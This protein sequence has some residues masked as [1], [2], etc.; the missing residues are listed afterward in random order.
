MS[1][2]INC[3]DCGETLGYGSSNDN[4]NGWTRGFKW[5][6]SNCGNNLVFDGSEFEVVREARPPTKL[7]KPVKKANKPID[8]K[9]IHC[10]CGGYYKPDDWNRKQHESTKKHKNYHA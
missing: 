7:T 3:P 2:E 5:Y 4:E 6:C 1:H 8:H 10:A 9:V